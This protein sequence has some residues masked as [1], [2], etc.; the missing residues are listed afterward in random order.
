MTGDDGE[1]A[2]HAI[3]AVRRKRAPPDC[4]PLSSEVTPV[5]S[6]ITPSRD[7][8]ALSAGDT[9]L[10]PAVIVSP[11][12]RGHLAARRGTRALHR[13]SLHLRPGVSGRGRCRAGVQPR[14]DTPGPVSYTHL[15]LPTSD[16]V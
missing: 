7:A 5:T 8:T 1:V 9:F 11:V 13:S 4:A 15:T 14:P 12:V 10:A 16:L 3:V 2:S 6:E